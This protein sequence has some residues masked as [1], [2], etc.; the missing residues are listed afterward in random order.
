MPKTRPMEKSTD[1]DWQVAALYRFVDLPRYAALR[2]PLVS[3]CDDHGIVGTLLLAREGINGTV[4]GKA[5]GIKALIEWLTTVPEFADLDVKYSRAREQPFHRLKIR[6]KKEIVTLGAGDL[7]PA[8]NAG[9]YVA[10]GEWNELIDDPD[11]IVIDTRND[12]EV[13]IGTFEGAINP[14]T[15]SFRDFPEWVE[16]KLDAQPG[17]RIAMF[18]TGGIRCE[19]ST[20]LLRSRGFENVYHLKGGILKYLEEVPETESRW[21]GECFVFDH[22]VSVGHGLEPGSY[23]MCHACRMPLSNADQTSPLYEPGVACPHCHDRQTGQQR[24]R[25]AERQKQTELARAREEK[26]IAAD[27]DAAKARK[28]RQRQLERE[29]AED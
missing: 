26:H 1:K 21:H 6:L 23:G 20:A 13:S 16:K 18:C 4:A 29:K 5:A 24:Q 8:R 12:Y 17:A 19:K 3:L 25:F 27:I 2:E 14:R 15:G 10:P 7:D 9:S 11:T 22:R 28:R